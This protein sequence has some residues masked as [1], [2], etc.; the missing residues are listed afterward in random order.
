MGRPAHYSLEITARC[1]RILMNLMPI[2]RKGFPGD[3]RHGGSLTTTFLLAVSTPAIVMP[4]ERIFKPAH[5]NF[6]LGDDRKLNKGLSAEV[7][8]VLGGKMKFAG[9][10]FFTGDWSYLPD[11]K[12]FNLADNWPTDVLMALGEPKAANAAG[13]A[14]AQMIITH[15]RNALAHGNITYLDKDGGATDGPAAMYGFASAKYEKQQNGRSKVVG[16]HALRVNEDGFFKFIV[17]W[18]DWIEKAGVAE[19]LN[20]DRVLEAAE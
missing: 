4:V 3:D 19:R 2:V 6:G 5:G 8:R 15:I 7:R 13:D 1:E 20:N 18:A 16:L 12:L 11:Q 10:P 14:Q 17:A 9:A